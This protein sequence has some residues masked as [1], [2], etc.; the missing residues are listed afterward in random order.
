M[1]TARVLFLF[2]AGDFHAG[3]PSPSKIQGWGLRDSNPPGSHFSHC[4]PTWKPLVAWF[5]EKLLPRVAKVIAWI[6]SALASG[7]LFDLVKAFV[8]H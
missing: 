5:R 3:L 2:R 4:L 1:E 6:V 8:G 7:V